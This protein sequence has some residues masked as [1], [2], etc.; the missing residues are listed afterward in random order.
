MEGVGGQEDKGESDD[1]GPSRTLLSVRL[2]LLNQV[3][4]STDKQSEDGKKALQQ[5]QQQ[6]KPVDEIKAYRAFPVDTALL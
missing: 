1:D 4:G 3:L 5:Q 6:R 2:I